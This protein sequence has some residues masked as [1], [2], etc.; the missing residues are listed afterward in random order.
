[1]QIAVQRRPGTQ[2]VTVGFAHATGFCRSVWDPVIDEMTA[3]GYA[4]SVVAWDHR[5]HGGSGRPPLP[6]DWWDTGRDALTVLA[7]AAAPILGV[8]HSMGAVSLLMAEILNPGTFASIVAI[9]PIAFPT[10]DEPI[11]DHPL[12]HTARRRKGSFPSREAAFENFASKPVFS[13][14]DRRALRAYVTCGLVSAGDEWRLACPPEYEAAFFVAGAAH[15]TWERLGEISAPVKVVAGA[16]SDTHPAAF[17]AQQAAR[18]GNGSLELVTGSGHFLPMEQPG[19]LAEII[20]QTMA[21][22]SSS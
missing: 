20:N 6:V 16:D 5:A 11:D 9:E 21:S 12:A 7:D 1:M 3:R 17:A 14:W 8:G 10:P 18:L 4:G 2:G 19:R 15:G 22:M 13:A